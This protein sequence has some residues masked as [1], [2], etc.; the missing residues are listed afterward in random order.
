MVSLSLMV[1]YTLWYLS[2][3]ARALASGDNSIG[4]HHSSDCET[5]TYENGEEKR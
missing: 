4:D 1:L 2:W 3:H 5:S